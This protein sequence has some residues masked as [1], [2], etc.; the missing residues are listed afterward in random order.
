MGPRSDFHST[1]DTQIVGPRSGF[2]SAPTLNGVRCWNS[3]LSECFWIAIDHTVFGDVGIASNADTIGRAT[4]A[5]TDDTGNAFNGDLG[6]IYDSQL[7]AQSILDISVRSVR[8]VRVQ[9]VSL[10][11]VVNGRRLDMKSD[12]PIKSVSFFAIYKIGLC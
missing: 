8:G 3:N 4:G 10:L 1:Q 11:Y 5:V 12:C 6:A 7:T 9:W 2:R